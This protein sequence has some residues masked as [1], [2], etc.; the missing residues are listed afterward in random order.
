MPCNHPR[1]EWQR[2]YEG[3]ATPITGRYFCGSCG[4]HLYAEHDSSPG[5]ASRRQAVP[6]T[7]GHDAA[8]PR[9]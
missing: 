8:S 7:A 9:P 1:E 3:G 5:N 4:E 6:I 2:V